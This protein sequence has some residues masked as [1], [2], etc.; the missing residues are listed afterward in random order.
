MRDIIVKIIG[1]KAYIPIKHFFKKVLCLLKGIKSGMNVYISP[2]AVIKNGHKIKTGNNVVIE[3]GVTLYVDNE[4]S[5]ITIG[6][7][8]YFSSNCILRTYNGWIKIGNNC[9]V[10]NYAFLYGH[11]GLEIGN[12]VRISTSVTIIPMNHIYEDPNVPICKQG[13]RAEGIKIEDD[14]WVGAGAK[15][16]DGV[17]IGKGSVVG[18]GAVVTKNIPPYSVS[19]GVPSKIIKK[20]DKDG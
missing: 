13:I 3:R 7:D 4:G 2:Y 10:N 6:D 18:A 12:N 9:T 20:R 5:C 14:V 15:I 8:S 1:E 16:L 19:V 11:G 17:T